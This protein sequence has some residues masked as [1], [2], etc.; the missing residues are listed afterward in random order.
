MDGRAQGQV[1][2][3]TDRMR[4]LGRGRGPENPVALDGRA[5]SGTT[6]T[7]LDPVLSLRTRLRLAPGGFAR[8]SFTTGVASDRPAAIGLAQ[9]FHDFGFAARTFA[10]A[11]TNARISLG[12]LGISAE[13]AQLYERLGSRVF[14]SDSSLRADEETLARNSLG[15]PG[16]WGHGISGDLPIVLVRVSGMEDLSLVRQVLKAHELWRLKG[17]KADAVIL[18]E[19]LAS[20][21]DELH[22]QLSRLVDSGPWSAWKGTPGGVFLLRADAMPEAETI[23]LQAVA[24]AVLAGNRGTL[25]SQ[26]D[27]PEPEPATLTPF[28][29]SGAPPEDGPP[30]EPVP[31]PSLT[32]GNGLGGFAQ[33]GREYVVVLEGDRETPL[34]WINVLANPRFGSI[35]TTSGSAHTWCESSREN[36]LTPFANDPVTDPTAEAIFLRDEESGALWGATPGPLGRTPDSPRW[37]VRHGAGVTRFL[38]TTLSLAQQLEV[39]VARDAPVKLSLLSLTNRSRHP[40]RLALFS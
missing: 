34:P 9:K 37:V 5:L 6:G 18:N 21:R 20:Y 1:E 4:F 10:L 8:L 36:R 13:E 23:L 25:L 39:F 31:L 40:R 17:L 11:Y 7:V 19:R 15:Q 3:E 38:T 14:F 28:V 24:Q 33:D 22:E 26:L 2:W 12:H 16:L 32:M 35:V 30:G 27:R 29:P